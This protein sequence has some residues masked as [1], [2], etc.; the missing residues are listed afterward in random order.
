ME[1]FSSKNFEEIQV[2]MEDFDF[3]QEDLR[4]LTLLETSIIQQNEQDNQSDL[5]LSDS[6]EEQLHIPKK[7]RRLIIQ[8][9]SESESDSVRNYVTANITASDRVSKKWSRPRRQQPSIIPFT[10]TSGMNKEFSTILK[11]ADPGAFYSLLV[12][13]EIFDM[14]V[15]QTNLFALQSC[16]SRN[17][18]PSSRSHAWKPTDRHEIKRFFGLILYMGLVRLPKLGYYWSKDK[19][20]GQTFPR[21][22]MSRNRF[23]IILQYLHFSDNETANKSDRISK[24]RPIIDMVN[25]TFQ[26]Y[27]SPKEDICVDESQV[28]FRGRIV[29]RQY[30]K[31]KRHKY[32]LKL[33]KLCTIPGYT[34]KF[35][36]YGGKNIDTVNTTPTSVVMSLCSQILNKGHTLATDN[37]YTSLELAYNLLEHQTHL[38]GT[39]R[40]N[41]RG[42]PK[43]VVEAKLQKG[44]FMAMENED[45]ITILKWKDKRDVMILST[46]HSDKMS[47]IAKKGKQITKPKVILDYN[48]SKGSVDMSDQMSSYSS[49]LRKTIKWYRKL[50]IEILLN[51]AVVNAWI[52]FTETRN[53]KMSIVEFRKSLVD[54]LTSS[55]DSQQ[56]E[57]GVTV[58]R[59]KRLK[60]ELL[61]KTGTVRN[62]RRF[63]V[64]C[65]KDMVKQFGRK[66]AKN[67]AKKVNTFL[68]SM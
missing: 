11:E 40:K 62:T 47:T 42:L 27:Y 5:E 33:F 37:W 17:V 38:I 26:K 6:N 64:H 51:T 46:K 39:I 34:C 31:S 32:G 24:I 61:T 13:D 44:E 22:V 59:P 43:D 65:Y 7:R 56:T 63:C 48:K 66:L 30:N 35:S 16:E 18:K 41:R 15:E 25:N 4:A 53:T 49:P 50:G 52:M 19:I 21:T 28:P 57:S 29:F 68:R 58:S 54:Y 3:T 2:D 55:S 20:L 12:S 23:E 67:K 9:D 36:L 45:G 14:I 1:I 10:E 8:S 60:H